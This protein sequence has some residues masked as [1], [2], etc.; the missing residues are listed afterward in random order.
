[1]SASECMSYS[2]ECGIK[3][4]PKKTFISRE[5]HSLNYS[6]LQ[7]LLPRVILPELLKISFIYSVG[8]ISYSC[9][10]WKVRFY[11][12]GHSLN[13]NCYTENANKTNY[14]QFIWNDECPLNSLDLIPLGLSRMDCDARDIPMLHSKADRHLRKW[15][16]VL[17]VIWADLRQDPI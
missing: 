3:T 4:T 9:L 1:M 11:T 12:T 5:W 16:T 13:R 10:N 15:I 8:N 2:T 17:Q 7:R 6:N 14:M